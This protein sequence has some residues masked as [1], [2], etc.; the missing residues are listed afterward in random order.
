[1]S[2]LISAGMGQCL[3][4]CGEV[5]AVVRCWTDVLI[6]LQQQGRLLGSRPSKSSDPS[7]LLTQSPQGHL[8]PGMPRESALGLTKNQVTE[9][10]LD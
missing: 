5:L 9:V 10:L 8:V 3:H 7:Y 2:M 4:V 1:M 6:S